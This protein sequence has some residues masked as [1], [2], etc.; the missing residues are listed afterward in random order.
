M[1]NFSYLIPKVLAGTNLPRGRRDLKWLFDKGIRILVTAMDES[2]D[3]ATVTSVGLTYHHY[4]VPPY[5]TPTLEQLQRFI[6]LV[7][8]SR[9]KGLPVCVHCYL[10]CGRTGTFL[11]A[12]IIHSE[13]MDGEKALRVIRQHRPCSIETRGQERILVEFA[14]YVHTKDWHDCFD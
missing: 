9:D 10:G 12:Y 7:D 5:G 8:D 2:L 1:D 11:A 3:E 4:Y 6:E 14:Q 13:R